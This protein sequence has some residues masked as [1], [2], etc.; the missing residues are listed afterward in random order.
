MQ[1][2]PPKGDEGWSAKTLTQMLGASLG[3]VS[4]HARALRDAGLIV[5]VDTRRAR[6]AV[7]T[8]YVLSDNAARR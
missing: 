4:Y 6:G 8:F 1:S 5:E 2:K 3:D 7:Q